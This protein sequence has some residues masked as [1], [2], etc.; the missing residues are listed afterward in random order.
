MPG[1]PP[2]AGAEG[3]EGAAETGCPFLLGAATVLRSVTSDGAVD[4]IT[5]LA[6]EVVCV[7][8]AI[9]GRGPVNRRR[10]SMGE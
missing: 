5:R 3:A 9:N 4:R 8:I 7:R 2:G 1:G 6:F 10:S